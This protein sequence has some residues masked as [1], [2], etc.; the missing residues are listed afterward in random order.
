M[1]ATSPDPI[2]YFA[3]LTSGIIGVRLSNLDLFEVATSLVDLLD[4][5]FTTDAR[6]CVMEDLI[7]VEA[8]L[9]CTLFE[10]SR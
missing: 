10:K 9:H 5:E 3:F 1:Q 6:I 2:F 8:V 4:Q 7:Q